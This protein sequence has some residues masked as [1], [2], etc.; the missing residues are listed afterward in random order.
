MERGG[1]IKWTGGALKRCVNGLMVS[2]TK[3]CMRSSKQLNVRQRKEGT[4][5]G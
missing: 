3:R 5:D 2:G 4:R 1:Y